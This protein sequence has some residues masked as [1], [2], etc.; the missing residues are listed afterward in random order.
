MTLGERIAL[1]RKQAKMSQQS[2]A[3]MIGVSRTT[4]SMWELGERIPD[5]DSLRRL[6]DVFG[7]TVD[8]L[9]RGQVQA[10]DVLD[11]EDV[12]RKIK[13]A[14][15]PELSIPIPILGVIRAGQPLFA[16]TNIEGWKNM[17]ARQ[18]QDAKYFFLRVTGDS[19]E[20]LLREGYLVL[21]RVQPD[22]DNGDVAVVMVDDENATIKRVFR[23]N[24][25]VIL[26][27]ENPRYQPILVTSEAARIIG[28]VVEIH[29]SLE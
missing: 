11:T 7:V 16:Q 5:A 17:S 28:K 12:W 24:G 15:Q 20:P 1:L 10:P 2:L 25:Q 29:I 21:V 3:K 18:V 19:M 4:I 22:V 13:E 8:Y 27:P 14:W 6:A 9:V 23:V 26:R